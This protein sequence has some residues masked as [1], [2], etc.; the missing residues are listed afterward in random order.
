MRMLPAVVE[1]VTRII[2][3][4]VTL[5]F[6]VILVGTIVLVVLRYGFNTTIVG[7]NELI[8]YLFIYTTAFGAAAALARR[9]HIK[10]T[11]FVDKLPRGLKA[12]ADSLGFLLVALINGV[13]IYYSVPWIRTVGGFE[14]PVLRLHNRII[15]I[16]V[17]I[18]CALVI[19]YCLVHVLSTLVNRGRPA[20]EA[21]E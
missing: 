11:W 8:E 12:A 6:F 19:I 5:C 13:M 17:P 21:Q 10:I 20:G 9:E 3:W 18:G 7:G 16:S 4:F 1:V 15:Q 14:S 2:E